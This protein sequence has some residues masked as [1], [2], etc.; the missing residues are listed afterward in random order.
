[1]GKHTC[2]GNIFVFTK[3]QQQKNQI[4]LLSN[5]F[6]I[7]LEVWYRNP[8]TLPIFLDEVSHGTPLVIRR[9]V[10]VAKCWLEEMSIRRNR[11]RRN[12]VH[13]NYPDPF[14]YKQLSSIILF[15]VRAAA[16]GCCSRDPRNALWKGGPPL[17]PKLPPSGPKMPFWAPS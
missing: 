12:V 3:M 16:R 14:Q 15:L 10:A 5:L 6:F 8:K 11:S 17:C 9:S 13:P 7:D 1:M 4:A 2:Q